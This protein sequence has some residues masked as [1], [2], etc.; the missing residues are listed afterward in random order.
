MNP[1][2]MLSIPYIKSIRLLIYA[3][4]IAT[5]VKDTSIPPE[6]SATKNQ[7]ASIASKE[8]PLSRSKRVSGAKKAGLKAVIMAMRAINMKNT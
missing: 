4:V 1:S 6:R 7:I 3:P 5:A 8:W 2:A